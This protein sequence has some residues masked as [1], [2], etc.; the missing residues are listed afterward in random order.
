M[1]ERYLS[2]K[3]QYENHPLV[4]NFYIVKE[5]LYDLLMQMKNILEK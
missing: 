3:S 1:K 4:Q 2:L 5:E